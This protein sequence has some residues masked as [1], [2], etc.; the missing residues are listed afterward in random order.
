LEAIGLVPGEQVRFRRRDRARWQV[1][2]VVCVERDGSLRVTD[3]DGAAR[4]VPLTHVQVQ[5]TR[6]A[7]WEPLSERSR[8]GLQMQ[9]D[10]GGRARRRRGRAA[11]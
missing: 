8:R 1:G 6:A 2:A 10:F 11:R 9:L 7:Q 4:A 5:A 3:E